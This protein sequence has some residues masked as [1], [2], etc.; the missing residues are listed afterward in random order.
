MGTLVTVPKVLVDLNV[1]FLDFNRMK[2]CLV[3]DLDAKY[4]LILGMEWRG[5][6]EPWIDWRSRTLG[7]TRNAPED[8]TV[9]D[10]SPGRSPRT[11]DSVVEN[12][13]DEAYD[14][15]HENDVTSLNT[16][17]GVGDCKIRCRDKSPIDIVTND[18]V[19]EDTELQAPHNEALT[20]AGGVHSV[21]GVVFDL[22]V[23]TPG[24]A[25]ASDAESI[26]KSSNDIIKSDGHSDQIYAL[27][28]GLT[29]DVEEPVALSAIPAVIALVELDELS[30]AE[31]NSALQAGDNAEVVIIQAEEELNSS[32][33][34]IL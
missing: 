14:M 29:G 11:V 1:K 32:G 23:C 16:M 15:C 33:F 9:E 28:N 22:E 2:R 31:F 13:L 4:D 12:P 19:F 7:A 27:I 20:Q 10:N 21:N 34:W 5:R 17:S 3:L 25:V 26:K 6:H 8:V 30:F 24:D 18:V